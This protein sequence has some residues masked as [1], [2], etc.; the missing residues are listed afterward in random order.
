LAP[1]EQDLLGMD[2]ILFFL[3]LPL[4]AVAVAVWV[5]TL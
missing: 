4:L 1:V 3:P 5:I 2:L